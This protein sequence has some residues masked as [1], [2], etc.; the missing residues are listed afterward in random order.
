MGQLT[1]FE[2][3]EATTYGGFPRQAPVISVVPV[4]H[5]TLQVTWTMPGMVKF[6]DPLE[7][8][9]INFKSPTTMNNIFNSPDLNSQDQSLSFNNYIHSCRWLPWYFHLIQKHLQSPYPSKSSLNVSKMKSLLLFSSS[10]PKAQV[11]FSN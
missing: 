4:D 6:Q 11:S 8:K 7:I 1:S 3:V 9:S 10:E 2:S 5:V